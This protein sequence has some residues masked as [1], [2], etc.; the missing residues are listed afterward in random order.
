MI[1]ELLGP[2]G[3]GKTTL[4]DA[5]A[6]RLRQEGYAVRTVIGRRTHLFS[7]LLAS[8][9]GAIQF[10]FPGTPRTGLAA[11]V[12]R[13]LPPRSLLWSMRL[14]GYINNLRES[15]IDGTASAD[16]T[17]LDQGFVQIIGSL[18]LLSGIADRSRIAE[19]LARIPKSD[20]VIRVNTPMELLE[21]RLVERR[22]HLGPVQRRLELNVQTSFEQVKIVEM[23]SGMLASAGQRFLTI[24]CPDKASLAAATEKILAEI[25]ARDVRPLGVVA[26]TGDAADRP[27]HERRYQ[28]RALAQR[29]LGAYEGFIRLSSLAA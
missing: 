13:L 5:L 29:Y 15:S 1:I 14:R 11:V 21:A 28:D 17:L 3:A 24:S 10:W 6:L 9:V 18:V 20:L 23:L 8:S 12:M 7:R 27:T 4:A 19:A 25:R 22:Q 26:T 16:I 2:S